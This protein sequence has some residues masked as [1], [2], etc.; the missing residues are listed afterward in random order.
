[1]YQL[2]YI[3][4]AAPSVG[5]KDLSRILKSAQKN[6]AS[7]AITGILMFHNHQ[8]LQ[9]LEGPKDAV[10]ACFARIKA[11]GRHR[12]IIKLFDEPAD[13][14]CFGEWSMAVFGLANCESS[15]R[16]QLIDLFEMRSHPRYDDLQKN[17]IIGVFVDTFLADMSRFG[18][19]LD[20]PKP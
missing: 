17:K 2:A 11:D 9:V 8:F 6:N 5:E 1:M 3:S 19:L 12:S 4:A 14:R 18:D 10:E 15:L 16:E 20:L 13:E 7:N